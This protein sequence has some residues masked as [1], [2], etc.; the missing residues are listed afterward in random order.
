VQPE[1][2][3]RLK[4]GDVKL[5]QEVVTPG[6]LAAISNISHDFALAADAPEADRR[7]KFAAWLSDARN[8]LPARVMANRVWHFHFGQGLVATP[9]DF[10]VSGA[11]PSHTE[12]LDWLAMKFIESGWSVKSLHRLIVNSAAYRQSS[13]FDEKAAAFDAENQLLWRFTPRRLEAEALRDAMLMVSGEMNW[14]AGGPSF[15]PFTVTRFNSDFYQIKDMPDPE[16][17]RR[18]VYRVNVNSAKE[19]LLDAFDC[20]DPSVK[21]P[22]RGATT[23]PLQALAL[24]ND[25]FVQRQAD[26]LAARALAEA[27]GDSTKVISATYRHALGRAATPEEMKRAT[28]AVN[29]RGLAH[30]CWALLN[31]TEFVYVR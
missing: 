26:K 25:S 15:R 24:M 18:T 16:F 1:P 11:R 31:S 8:P 12:L 19:P 10:G 7:M 17:N 4:R 21:T 3:H 13:R 14:E 23:T 30:V 28:E 5:P 27:K 22:R 29:E 2:T 9:N 20:P 6:A